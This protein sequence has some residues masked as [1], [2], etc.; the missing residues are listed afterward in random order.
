MP[1]KWQSLCKAANIEE[2]NIRNG[3]VLRNIE[4]GEEIIICNE[5]EVSLLEPSKMHQ[6]DKQGQQLEKIQQELTDI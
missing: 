5:P 1:P 2:A 3:I 4:F 6:N